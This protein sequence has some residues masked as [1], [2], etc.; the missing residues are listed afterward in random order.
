MQDSNQEMNSQEIE[1]LLARLRESIDI[2]E[3]KP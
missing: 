1:Q 2:Y 3:R